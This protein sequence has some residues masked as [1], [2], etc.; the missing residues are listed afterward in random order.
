MHV[1]NEFLKQARTFLQANLV[2]GA[3]S[4]IHCV[5]G[6]EAAGQKPKPHFLTAVTAP[7]ALSNPSL[8]GLWVSLE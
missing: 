1:V 5:L 8:Y 6:N 2:P 7:L 4:K 3:T